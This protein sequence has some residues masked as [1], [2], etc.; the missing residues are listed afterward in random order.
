[1]KVLVFI[2]L[3]VIASLCFSQNS[4]P[5]EKWNEKELELVTNFNSIT[6]MDSTEKEILFYTNLVRV[7]PKLF[8]K[9][10]LQEYIDL[11]E[12]AISNSYISSLI[13]T[14]N[15][16]KS[17]NVL[18][19]DTNLFEMAKDHATTMGVK[20]MVG[21]TGFDKRS[22]KFLKN[23]F[24]GTGENCSYGHEKSIDIFMSLLID[25]D[26]PSLGHRNNLLTSDFTAVGISIQPHKKYGANCVMDF[27]F[28]SSLIKRKTFIQKL[29]FWK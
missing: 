3:Q 7:N 1:M 6:Y 10:Y 19:P 29:L 27:G 9:T 11:N 23:K 13:G 12:L 16:L 26:V 4:Y 5:Y 17:R 15:T 24:D 28:Q 22:A 18:Q 21:H 8:C 14:L 2:F 20:G 25:E